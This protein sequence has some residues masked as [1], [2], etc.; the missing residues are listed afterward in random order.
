MADAK[1]PISPT[2]FDRM[3]KQNAAFIALSKTAHPATAGKTNEQIKA[4]FYANRQEVQRGK[5]E[6]RPVQQKYNFVVGLSD[7]QQPNNSTDIAA[8]I[9]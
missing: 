1:N 8:R 9:G 2:E 4:L 6:Y 7:E 3:I 5:S